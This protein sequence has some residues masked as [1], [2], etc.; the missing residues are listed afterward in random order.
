MN[1]GIDIDGVLTNDDEYLLDFTSKYCYEN[2]L[3]GFLDANLYEYSKYD[4][5]ENTINNYRKKY[6]VNYCKNVPARR[7]ASEVIKKLRK[8]GHKIF[9]ITGRHKTAN[10]GKINNSNIR[11]CT[12]KWLRKNKIEYDKA[13][14][15]LPPKVNEVIENKIDL[16]IEDTPVTINELVKVVKVLYYDTPYNK[17]IENENITRVFSWY[18][19]YMKIK[20]ME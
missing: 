4:W 7:F 12:L 15:T 17:N 9:I 20:N 18:D 1:I 6:F 11:K 5:D 8:D 16:M 3:S 14:F 19:I 2:N 13:I 10:N